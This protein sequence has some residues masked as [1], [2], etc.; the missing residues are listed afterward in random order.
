MSFQLA[1]IAYNDGYL[2]SWRDKP[3]K[4]SPYVSSIYKDAWL[5]GYDEERKNRSIS[6]SLTVWS[7]FPPPVE[8][9]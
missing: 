7:E 3:R 8:T 4:V 5:L 9:S 2:A 6:E 1:I